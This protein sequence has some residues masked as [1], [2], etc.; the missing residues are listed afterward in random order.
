MADENKFDPP[1]QSLADV[2]HDGVDDAVSLIPGAGVLFRAII[3]PPM[4][5]R[6]DKWRNDVGDALRSLL[7]RQVLT[8]ESLKDEQFIDTLLQASQAAT[9]TS[10]QLKRDALRNAVLNAVLPQAPDESRQTLFIQYVDRFSTFHL[11]MLK[12]L[13]D[14]QAW[15]KQTER[16]QPQL[17]T[18]KL[19][20]LVAVAFPSMK[21]DEVLCESVCR[22]LNDRG[23]LIANSLRKPIN[24]FPYRPQFTREQQEGYRF[25]DELPPDGTVAHSGDPTH[26]RHWT[27]E[28]GRQFLD[29]I[30][31]PPA[32]A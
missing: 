1:Q 30:S 2:F 25:G 15:F 11:A 7:A 26:W 18:D 20:E 23:L 10:H 8:M 13:D 14:P 19:F 4:E 22:D 6:L 27:T 16:A 21:S 5:R 12:M 29:F 28:L 31:A 17:R 9:R 32:S 3:E 24:R